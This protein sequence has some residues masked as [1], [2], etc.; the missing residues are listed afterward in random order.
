MC[1]RPGDGLTRPTRTIGDLKPEDLADFADTF[2]HEARHAEQRFL[3]ARLAVGESPR[4]GT[5]RLIADE[6]KEV[7][8][9]ERAAA[10]IARPAR[11][12]PARKE[13]KGRPA[14]RVLLV[15]HLGYKM[16][17]NGLLGAASELVASLSGEPV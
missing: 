11:G 6:I 2:F 14:F 4:K 12:L 3:M 1:E 10:A 7:C 16:W 17:N 8:I 5:R 13:C 15:K 9:G